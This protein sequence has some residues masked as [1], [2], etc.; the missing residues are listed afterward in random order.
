MK[1]DNVK[2][3]NRSRG[4]THT[5]MMLLRRFYKNVYAMFRQFSSW[6]D[7]SKNLNKTPK[8]K[9]SLVC[10][11][12]L[13]ETITFITVFTLVMIV[14]VSSVI[15]FY[16]SNTYTV[17]QS[18]AVNSARKGIE[19]MVRDI[20]EATYSDLGSYPLIDGSEYSIYFYSDIDRDDKVERI[21]YFL[22]GTTLKKGTTESSG[23]PLI[24]NDG[25]EV[26]STISEEV[27][28]EEQSTP[29]FKFYDENSGEIFNV[30][31]NLTNVAF[32]TVNLIVNI[33][34]LRLPNEFTLRSS[35]ALRNAD[36]GL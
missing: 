27:R 32:V 18:F 21:R 8:T 12:T 28:N 25:N 14:I 5:P 10:G 9:A 34:P 16:R 19:F 36:S 17:E 1:N 24:Y 4:F 6:F 3:K 13:I 26:I 15:Y 30:P 33:N 2:L 23:N 22:E 31:I 29:I 7:F 11:F 20:R 35:A